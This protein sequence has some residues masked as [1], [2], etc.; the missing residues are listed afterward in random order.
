VKK[1]AKHK[2]HFILIIFLLI[3]FGFLSTT[4]FSYFVA[5]ESFKNHIKTHVLPLTSDNVYSEIQRDLLPT[6]II[7]SVMAQDTFVQDW[8]TEGE[9][10]IDKMKTYLKSIQTTYKMDTAFFVSQKTLKYYHPNGVLRKVSL[11]NPNDAWYPRVE[12][13]TDDFE[14]NVDI[15]T[16]FPKRT[17]IFV[18][19]KILGKNNQY[20]GAIG[21]GLSSD[22]VKNIINRYQN[23]FGR[24]VY[25]VKKD[26]DIRY[27]P[28]LKWILF[29]EQVEKPETNIQKTLWLNLIIG[30]TITLLILAL[31]YLTIRKYQ[32]RLVKMA[33][34]DK[35]TGLDNR[36]AFE[37]TFQHIVKTSTRNKTKLCMIL[38]DIDYFK[39]INDHYGHLGGDVILAQF[40]A[41]LSKN[42]RA[43]D[44]L[45][46]WGG[47]EF[48][49]LLPECD[50]D[51]ANII[52]EKIR[53]EISKH[54]FVFEQNTINISASFGI[55]EFKIGEREAHLITRADTAL[56]N[57]KRHGRNRVENA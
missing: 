36:Y 38:I 12:K 9:K 29:V 34:K 27:I 18:N 15:D 22:N 44:S 40:A 26:G 32:Q 25:F 6:T 16:A 10:D 7:S 37:S 39:T 8:I 2:S 13:L 54:E 53:L 4:L 35:L 23:K 17:T 57:A 14:M 30:L 11:D 31:T 50:R 45:C 33:T 46:R 1:I 3:I 24:Q 52:A 21:V 19:H 49:M 56:Y 51:N 41:L 43:S 28:E 20:L 42:L 55:S 47:E 5:K 48:V